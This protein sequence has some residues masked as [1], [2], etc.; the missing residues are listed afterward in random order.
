MEPKNEAVE[1]CLFR[2]GLRCDSQC[3]VIRS[4]H[5]ERLFCSDYHNNVLSKGCITEAGL[6]ISIAENSCRIGIQNKKRVRYEG[7]RANVFKYGAALRTLLHRLGRQHGKMR[8]HDVYKIVYAKPLRNLHN[9]PGITRIGQISIP[10]TSSYF[11]RVFAR[12]N[13]VNSAP[14]KS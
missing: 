2:I 4:A 1:T 7:D 11:P 8:G 10:R 9:S 3:G 12:S 6:R 13:Q 14:S 5:L